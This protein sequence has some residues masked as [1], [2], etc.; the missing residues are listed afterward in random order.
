MRRAA[1]L[2]GVFLFLAMLGMLVWLIAG[3]GG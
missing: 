3:L 2:F 1:V